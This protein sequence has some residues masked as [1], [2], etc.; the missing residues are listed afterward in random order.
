MKTKM[1]KQNQTSQ[2][3]NDEVKYWESKGPLAKGKKSRFHAPDKKDLCSSFLSVRMTGSELDGLRELAQR[4]DLGPST[5]ARQI[6]VRCIQAEKEKQ[7]GQLNRKVVKL[8][9]VLDRVMQKMPDG[10]KKRFE[11]IIND[12]TLGDVSDPQGMAMVKNQLM[13][14]SKISGLIMCLMIEEGNP[15]VKVERFDNIR[16]TKQK[17]TAGEK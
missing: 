15:D 1:N 2:P 7:P 14:L 8:D 10:V 17:A 13:E 5:L 12:T 16:E 9:D 3:E 6:L 11:A 4:Y